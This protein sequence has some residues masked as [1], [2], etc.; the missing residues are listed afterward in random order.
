MNKTLDEYEIF[1]KRYNEF[2]KNLVQILTDIDDYW[3]GRSGDSFKYICW[4]LKILSD[5]G[6]DNLDGLKNE[7]EV[8][9]KSHNYNDKNLSNQIFIGK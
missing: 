7:I 9:I 1:Q 5:K 8:A 2:R 4:Y 6:Y 3:I